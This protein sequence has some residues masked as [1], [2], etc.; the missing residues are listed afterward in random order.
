V[1]G[2][3]CCLSACRA[4]EVIQA[5]LFAIAT[6]SRYTV[7]TYSACGMIAQQVPIA[8]VARGVAEISPALILGHFP[9]LGCD[10]GG[11]RTGSQR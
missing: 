5:A 9:D 6:S 4:A 8:G 11:D 7:A 1:I 10:D 3:L 2:I